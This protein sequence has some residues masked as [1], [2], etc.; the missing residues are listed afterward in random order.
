M[1]DRSAGSRGYPRL[2]ARPPHGRAS[3]PGYHAALGWVSFTPPE[4][5]SFSA[6]QAAPGE[7]CQ[8]DRARLERLSTRLQGL[9][10]MDEDE[11][12]EAKETNFSD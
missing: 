1:T 11:S 2:P 4:W 8:E 12:R 5:V 3:S 10:R 7:G 9:M 6:P